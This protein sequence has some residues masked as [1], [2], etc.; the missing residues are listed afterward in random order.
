MP[1]QSSATGGIKF[2]PLGKQLASSQRTATGRTIPTV[3]LHVI[4][5]NRLFPAPSS[6]IPIILQSEVTSV[7]SSLISS[8]SPYTVLSTDYMLV[9]D[10]A[11]GNMTINIPSATGSGS[12]LI[13]K[14]V[15]STDHEVA[16]EGDGSDTI[17]GETSMIL[18]TQYTSI[19][20]KDAATATW[21]IN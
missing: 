1:S 14:K 6:G 21:Y 20:I 17:D 13:I 16:I 8:D 15:D 19:T 2:L 3:P 9:C 4:P 18:K 10:A 5:R 12:T 11:D 7:V